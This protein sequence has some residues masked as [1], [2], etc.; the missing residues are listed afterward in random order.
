MSWN[1]GLKGKRSGAWRVPRSP[2][3]KRGGRQEEGEGLAQGPAPTPPGPPA[4][5]LFTLL[6]LPRH[7]PGQP[8]G[9]YPRMANWGPP[10]HCLPKS[11]SLP[12]RGGA[13]PVFL[14][15]RAPPLWGAV[16]RQWPPQPQLW[17]FLRVWGGG[18]LQLTPALAPCPPPSPR[19]IHGIAWEPKNPFWR[20]H[21][22]HFIHG[23][24]EAQRSEETCRSLHSKS[25][26]DSALHSAGRHEGW[27]ARAGLAGPRHQLQQTPEVGGSDHADAAKGHSLQ[28][29][30][31]ASLQLRNGVISRLEDRGFL[32][33]LLPPLSGTLG[34]PAGGR[35]TGC[36]TA[37]FSFESQLF[38]SEKTRVTG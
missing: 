21:L 3:G 37:P 2:P 22:F 25:A 13:T 10:P 32:A 17:F 14:F 28:I 23:E 18:G 30:A 7:C 34:A 11:P 20:A 1:P 19:F 36:W 5:A 35:G 26:P 8:G 15:P 33:S 27:S 6:G 29:W 4:Q 38:L 24:T 16:Q 12:C 31:F 9:L